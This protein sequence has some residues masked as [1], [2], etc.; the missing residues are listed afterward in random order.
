MIERKFV[1]EKIKEFQIGEYIF[2]NLPNIG[3]SH[4]KLQRTPLGEKITI[5]AAR[6]GLVVGRSGE[7]IKKL[8][9]SLKKK[10]GLENPQ[11]EI[12]EVENIYLN[13]NIVAESIASALERFGSQRFKGIGHKAMSNVMS[14]GARGIEIV[15]SGKIPGARAKSW[16]FYVGYLK[17]CGNVAI[18]GV[19]T[20]YASAQLKSGVI[21]VRVKIMQPDVLLPDKI[22][23]IP[24]AEVMEVSKDK[25]EEKKVE[26]KVEV[27]AEKK[28]KEAR[29]KKKK[30]ETKKVRKPKKEAEEKPKEQ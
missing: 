2:D 9:K 7:T 18:T 23:L 11:I 29:P 27:K 4:T 8:T 1:A 19:Q 3:H 12:S 21:G 26:E 17:K 13:A 22:E 5:Y 25:E 10:F 28:P 20:A 30:S 24:Q 6:P 16:R 15:L 14:A